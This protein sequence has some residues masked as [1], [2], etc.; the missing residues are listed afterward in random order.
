MLIGYM[1]ES[2]HSKDPKSRFAGMGGLVA[3]CCSWKQLEVTWEDAL[4]KAGIKGGFHMKHFAHRA[5]EFENWSED[6]RR[7]LFG[8]LV[9]AIVDAGAVPVGCVVSLDDFNGA[10]P[11][12]QKFHQEPY[13]MA[14]QMVTRG[15]SLQAIPTTYPYTPET[16]AMVYAY[17]QEYGA[18]EAKEDEDQA[19]KAQKLWHAMKR[20]TVYGQWM[21]SYASALAS[22]LYP[23][24]AADLFA[25]ELTKEFENLI[26]RPTDDMRWAL[27]QILR[28]AS[29]YN[30]HHLIQ[31]YDAH[32]MIR[33]FLEAT[34]QDSHPTPAIQAM[35]ANVWLR[36]IVARDLMQE[37]IR[38][39]AK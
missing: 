26:S 38:K 18:T 28:P 5:G 7:N 29:K 36:K 25:Y 21:G 10:S 22:E 6:Q 35:L 23:L 33:V 16:V 30:Q 2:G 37:R 34:G 14:F 13:F 19:G 3:D 20:L 4:D 15:V 39:Y 11:M 32:E 1:D 17:Q 24:Q 31:F 8:K 9:G 27:R 12:L